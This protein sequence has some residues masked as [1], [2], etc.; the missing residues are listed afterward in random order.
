MEAVEA[1]FNPL[2][3]TVT[4]PVKAGYYPGGGKVTLKLTA[5]HKSGKLLG[6]QSLGDN[7]VDKIIDTVAAALTGKISVPDLTNL[8]LTYAPPY[9]LALGTVIVAASVLEGKL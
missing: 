4:T 2:S 9:S 7:A 3:V 1:G 5:D 8:D 6:A